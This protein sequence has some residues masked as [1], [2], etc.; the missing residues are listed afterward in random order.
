MISWGRPTADSWRWVTKLRMRGKSNYPRNCSGVQVEPLRRHHP[1]T[2]NLD[3]VFLEVRFRMPPRLNLFTV[4]TPVPVLRQSS[5]PSV[6]HPSRR[7]IVTALNVNK[8]NAVKSGLAQRRW[9]SSG[10]DNKDDA[11]RLK[12]PTEDPLPHVSQEAAE[13]TKIMDKKCDGTAASPE[14]EQGT[15][16]SEVGDSNPP[17]FVDFLSR[18]L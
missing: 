12:G 14:L 7:S 10:S 6:N 18:R 4:R 11:D 2:S 5:T 9:N 16:I 17:Y 3:L 13:V 15:P 1:S 8:P